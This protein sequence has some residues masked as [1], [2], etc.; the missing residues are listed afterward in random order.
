MSRNWDQESR[1]GGGEFNSRS[2]CVPHSGRLPASQAQHLLPL[3]HRAT[4]A[5]ARTCPPNRARAHR[6]TGG[7]E[8]S[9]RPSRFPVPATP[10]PD[11]ARSRFATPR[12]T[13]TPTR[14]PRVPLHSR[15]VSGPASA[16]AVHSLP[17]LGGPPRVAGRV[18]GATSTHLADVALLCRLPP[19]RRLRSGFILCS[20]AGGGQRFL[21]AGRLRLL[22]PPSLLVLVFLLSLAFSFLRP[23]ATAWLSPAE[24]R[25]AP[26]LR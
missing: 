9:R 14:L 18:R 10:L 21:R 11:R 4:W 7:G 5:K 13:P 20:K 23:V 12:A 8:G 17:H 19:P 6:H 1:R 22:P 2:L 16:V 3:P 24:T 15:L 25:F 26:C